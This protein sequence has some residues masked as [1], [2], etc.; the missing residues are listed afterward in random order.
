M[1]KYKVFITEESQKYFVV[2]AKD[3]DEAERIAKERYDNGEAPIDTLE[4]GYEWDDIEEI[5]G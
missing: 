2:D 5:V 1:P 4:G 3:K